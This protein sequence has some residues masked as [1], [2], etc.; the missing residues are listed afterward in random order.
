MAKMTPKLPEELMSKLSR[1]GGKT[2]ILCEHAL[3]E[4]AEIVKDA[5]AG[6]LGEAVGHGTKY[7]SR[8]TGELQ[9]SLGISRVRQSQDGTLDIK[10]GFSEPRKDGASNAK[11]ANVLEYGKPGQPPTG[12][13][14]KAKNKSKKTA[15]D[16]MSEVLEKEMNG[17]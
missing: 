6:T 11:I 5:V 7:D 9:S 13:L 14:K 1:L 15:T 12:F 2:D 10:I 4:G 8:S 17:V 16:R 3:K